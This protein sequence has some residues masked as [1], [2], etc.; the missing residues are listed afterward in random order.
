[1]TETTTRHSRIDEAR[2]DRMLEPFQAALLAAVG[3]LENKRVVDA[4]CGAGATTIALCEQGAS[5]FAVDVD[6]VVL[7]R[8]AERVAGVGAKA[9]FAIADVSTHDFAAARYDAVVSRFA[10]MLFDPLGAALTNLRHALRPGGRL[11]ASVWQRAALNVWH[12]LPAEIVS[13]HAGLPCDL[14]GAGGPFALANA[15]LIVTH[16]NAADFRN[17]QVVGVE[18]NVWVGE[19]AD[20]VVAFF[21]RDAGDNLRRGFGDAITRAIFDELRQSLNPFLTPFGVEV[22]AAA[23]LVSADA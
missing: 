3:E 12:A 13:K 15:D 14:D 2:Y 4:G 21:D 23:W 17:V 1:M 7:A 5:V 19:D 18:H 16:M 9:E 20:D 6:R 11:A 8:A 22:P 10:L